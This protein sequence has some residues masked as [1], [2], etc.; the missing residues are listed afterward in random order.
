MAD[1][2]SK[3][4]ENPYVFNKNP[5]TGIKEERVQLLYQDI[6][7]DIQ[8]SLRSWDIFVPRIEAGL[9]KKFIQRKPFYKN[10]LF[11]IHDT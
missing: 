2:N 8:D 1:F 6:L 9:T 7:R 11:F 10:E 4:G 5:M 3:L